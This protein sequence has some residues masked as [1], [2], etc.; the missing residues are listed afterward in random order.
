MAAA[1]VFVTC[2]SRHLNRVTT[3]SGFC[4]FPRKAVTC[5]PGGHLCNSTIAFFCFI[6]F[7]TVTIF[8]AKPSENEPIM[9]EHS[10]DFRI[11]FRFLHENDGYTYLWYSV[12]NLTGRLAL[13]D[14]PCE[15]PVADKSVADIGLEF[16]E[17][18]EE[19][20]GI[21][22]GSLSIGHAVSPR[23]PLFALLTGAKHGRRHPVTATVTRKVRVRETTKL[24]AYDG[25]RIHRANF[26]ITE[27][28]L[29]KAPQLMKH[30]SYFRVPVDVR[31]HHTIDALQGEERYFRL[32][33]ADAS[34]TP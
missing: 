20:V 25:W 7:S 16:D 32:P 1:Q 2:S 18:N 13:I 19:T 31:I 26:W 3:T 17:K 12:T 9:H 5:F 8:A 30:A 4:A 34:E 29:E 11:R 21:G 28:N 33:K 27:L 23:T 14:V 10:K 24:R 15:G 6:F 22:F